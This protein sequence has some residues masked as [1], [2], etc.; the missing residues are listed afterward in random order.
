M[1]VLAFSGHICGNKQCATLHEDDPNSCAHVW[2]CWVYSDTFTYLFFPVLEAKFACQ[3]RVFLV[4]PM[5]MPAKF[6]SRT[7]LVNCASEAQAL[8][9][10]D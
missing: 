6:S 3:Y 7:E 2:Q 1:Y 5:S 10:A 4:L 9:P 8:Q